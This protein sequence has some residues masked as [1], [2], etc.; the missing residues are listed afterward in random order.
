MNAVSITPACSPRNVL[1]ASDRL[2]LLRK[3]LEVAVHI[4]MRTML[5]G[6]RGFGVFVAAAIMLGIL[7]AGV[8]AVAAIVGALAASQ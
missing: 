3:K 8:G 5:A 2:G 7:C 1:A 4:L 6:A